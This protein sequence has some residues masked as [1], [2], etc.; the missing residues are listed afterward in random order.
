MLTLVLALLAATPAQLPPPPSAE[1]IEAARTEGDRLLREAGAEDLFLNE[2]GAIGGTTV[3]VMLRHKAS[4][5]LCVMKVG[6]EWNKVVVYPNP[7]RGDDV[8]CVSDS[9]G[10]LRTMFVTRSEPGVDQQ[11]LDASIIALKAKY[12]KAKAVKHGGQPIMLPPPGLPEPKIAVFNV[13]KTDERIDVGVVDGWAL[14]FRYT[15]EPGVAR[16]TLLDM[17]WTTGVLEARRYR[18]RQPKV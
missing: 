13:G 18:E 3:G 16:S 8:G 9:I 14:K 2:S 5:F 11:W 4:G 12:P 1:Q 10:D 17:F 15:T 6:S 7:V